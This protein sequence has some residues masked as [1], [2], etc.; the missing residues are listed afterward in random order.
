MP[1]DNDFENEDNLAGLRKSAREGQAA[2]KENET[3]RRQLMFTKAG[4]E[5][6][7][8]DSVGALLFQTWNGGDDIEALKA[9]ATKVGAIKTAPTAS[10]DDNTRGDEDQQRQSAYDSFS[11]GAPSGGTEDPGPDPTDKALRDFHDP[12][13]RTKSRE[14]RQQDAITSVIAA[15]LRGDKRVIFD[16]EAHA[17]EAQRVKAVRGY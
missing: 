3:L 15:G 9:R 6:D 5:I 1:D 14:E 17:A 8:P 16:A 11:G 10:P 2:L 7:D 4:I 12:V 13:N